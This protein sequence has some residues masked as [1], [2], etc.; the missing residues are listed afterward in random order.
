[1]IKQPIRVIVRTR[2]TS[3]FAFKNIEIDPATSVIFAYYP[4]I[5]NLNKHPEAGRERIDQ[6]PTRELEVQIRQDSS[7]HKS[8]RC[9]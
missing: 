9:V 6:Q 8:G 1:M 3:N 2:P 7:Q 4:S 5:V